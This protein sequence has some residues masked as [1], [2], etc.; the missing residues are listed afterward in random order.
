MVLSFPS[1]PHA[2][3]TAKDRGSYAIYRANRPRWLKI[4]RRSLRIAYSWDLCSSNGGIQYPVMTASSAEEDRVAPD[5][6]RTRCHRRLRRSRHVPRHRR[7]RRDLARQSSGHQDDPSG[8]HAWSRE[9]ESLKRVDHRNVGRLL[10]AED[11][12]VAGVR[13]EVLR[14]VY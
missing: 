4:R 3:S 7:L 13:R 9:V 5:F 14:F 11:I 6:H 12:E 8:L 2:V 1:E 10:E